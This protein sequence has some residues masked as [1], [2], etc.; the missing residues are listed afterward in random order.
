M[1][2]AA[3]L[4]TGLDDAFVPSGRFE[5]ESAF[6]DIMRARL[7]HIH[8]LPCV[9]SQDRC[10]CVPMVGGANH[11]RIDVLLL[12][13][14]SHIGN[15]L[16][17]LPSLLVHHSRGCLCALLVHVAHRG[18]GHILHSSERLQQISPLTTR[19]D[20]SQYNA[21]TG[22]LG[23]ASDKGRRGYKCAGFLDKTPAGTRCHVQQL[24]HF[25]ACDEHF[26]RTRRA[27]CLRTRCCMKSTVRV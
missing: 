12:Q 15:G 4:C 7:F 17:G 13:Q 26:R 19:P 25:W 23:A 27:T 3:R 18:N 6:A 24:A 8:V 1:R 11:H 22:R 21:I 10:R 20:E 14:C 16:R 2:C 9:T 5:H